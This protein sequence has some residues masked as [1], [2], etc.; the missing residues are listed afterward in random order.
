[1]ATS[2][3][4]KLVVSLEANIAKFTTDMH[5]VSQTTSTAMKSM[6]SA[7][8]MAKTALGA[9]GVTL[10]AGAALSW[11]KG[12]VDAAA[13]LQHLS[14]A[15]GSS[16]ESLS[17]YVNQ[18][19]LAGVSAS[20]ASGLI[21][22]M[23]AAIGGA[24]QGA[25]KAQEALKLLGV[26]AR[27]PATALFEVAKAL[28]KYDDGAN[29]AA[30][31]MA[32][33]RRSG[34]DF[35]AMLHDMV[36][37]MQASSTVTAEQARQ[38]EILG[39]QIGLLQQSFTGLK[40][41]LLSDIVPALN[42]TIAQL[43]AAR[44][45]GADFI[46]ALMAA[47]KTDLNSPASDQIAKIRKEIESLEAGELHWYA[48]TDSARKSAI[49]GYQ[50]QLVA[51]QALQQQ[52]TRGGLGAG[53]ADRQ[54]GDYATPKGQAPGM[55]PGGEGGKAAVDEYTRALVDLAKQAAV[56][57]AALDAAFTGNEVVPALN[58]ILKKMA[59][60]TWA[61][62]TARQQLNLQVEASMVI[63]LQQEEAAVKKMLAATS[64]S[65][66]TDEKAA[67]AKQKLI[68]GRVAMVQSYQE[69]NERLRRENELIGQSELA[70]Q[71]LNAEMENEA[72][73]RKV[74]G[75]GAEEAIRLLRE[76]L[77]VRKQLIT[78]GFNKGE[79]VKG[80][81]EQEDAFK[82]TYDSISNTITDAL[83]RGFESGKD[84]AQNFIAT[85]KNMFSTLVLRPIVQYAVQGTASM[86]GMGAS[87]AGMGGGADGAGGLGGL[88][89][90]ASGASSLFG[91]T[92]IGSAIGAEAAAAVGNIALA[93][94]A[95]TELALAAAANAIPVIGTVVAVGYLL[96]NILSQ[97]KGGP[98]SGGFATSGGLAGINVD[99]DNSRYYT[100][101]QMDAAMQQ[102]VD[103]IKLSYLDIIKA[104]GG[105]AGEAIFALGGD[106]DPKGTAGNRVSAG[107]S[108]NGVSVYDAR[109]IA[110]GTSDEELQAALKTESMRA[111]L[112]ALQ[113]S[114]VPAN[115]AKILNSVPAAS[116]SSDAVTAIIAL[117]SAWGALTQTL[118]I[119]PLADMLT[120]IGNAATDS[121]YGFT[122][123]ASGLRKLIDGFDG[124]LQS[125]QDLTAGTIT[126]KTA[127][128][129]LIV[130]IEATRTAVNAM[131]G[132]TARNIRLQTL[133][134]AAQYKFY[135]NEATTLYDELMA[136]SDPARIK[137]LADRI[138]AD[139]TAAFGL[140]DPAAQK[141]KLPEYLRNLDII[142]EGVNQRLTEVETDIHQSVSDV[143]AEINVK[144]DKAADKFV[145]AADTNLVAAN[146]PLQ[147]LI[148]FRDAISDASVNG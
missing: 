141:D 107:A 148:D 84:I 98:K 146:T 73:I 99:S 42:T 2:E 20:D 138:N 142:T 50:L 35:N 76:E 68:E 59:D 145:V 65:I 106:A 3:I 113:K 17:K 71:L 21:Y 56:A 79:L 64:E 43:N 77:V 44:L 22:R 105:K 116:A 58:D 83:M 9:L 10:S 49:E 27:D 88:G 121:F 115:I 33:F 114:D 112:A 70:H 109:N 110:A 131:F 136:S 36:G 12:V 41:V 45:A 60:P 86:F 134:P 92:G 87:A 18:A 8:D 53:S 1:M 118:T 117:G 55:R 91:L 72:M 93:M 96:Y 63:G 54:A 67:E 48:V 102:A 101:N 61:T 133:D 147:V 39:Q 34:V 82:K 52:Q 144:L 38:A 19:Q 90:L 111:L 137:Q 57:Q 37:N 120:E 31:T 62:F 78:E 4:A 74:T 140:L 13:S 30:L 135:T 132:D 119:E 126:Y 108:L 103:T 81:K 6:T 25:E 143:L 95:G 127:A 24:G 89:S 125:V 11:A 66:K 122:N 23:S 46:T 32:I 97:A 7:A 80:L 85:L 26:S 40:N 100:P 29:K 129:Q 47:L 14:Q 75:E 123:L 124:S 130:A 5:S 128:M 15:T 28:D 51:L 94:G 69:G 16:V 104:F 139:I